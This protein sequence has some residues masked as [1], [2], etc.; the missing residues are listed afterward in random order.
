M[1]E[2]IER[3]PGVTPYSYVEIRA[4]QAAEWQA[5]REEVLQNYEALGSPESDSRVLPEGEAIEALTEALRVPESPQ[6]V[7]GGKAAFLSK[8]RGGK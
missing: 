7:S 2:I 3:I 5:L 1:S 4:S 6:T 8:A